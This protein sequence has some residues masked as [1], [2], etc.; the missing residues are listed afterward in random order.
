MAN[1]LTPTTTTAVKTAPSYRP[2]FLLGIALFLIGLGLNIGQ[3]F[4]LKRFFMPWYMPVLA[5]LG[6]IFMVAATIRKWTILRIVLAVIF[7]VLCGLQWL[8]LVS[9]TKVPAYTGPAQ[10][11]QPL[12]SFQTKLADGNPW[13]DSDLRKGQSS[14]LVFFRGHW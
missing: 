11:G 14:V 9:L 10:P 4:V 12:P 8:F 13:G 6:V 3:V 7:V 5:T 2:I 1:T